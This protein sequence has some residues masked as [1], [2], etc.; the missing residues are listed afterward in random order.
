MEK[1]KRVLL[2]KN[3]AVGWLYFYI[4]FVTEVVCFYYI[5][6][7]TNGSFVAWLIPFLYDALAFVPQGIIGKL[8]DKYPKLN[9]GI[10][11]I[12]LL[13]V[14]PIMQ[15]G[16]GVNTILCL[17]ILTLGNCIMHISGAEDTLRT[18]NGMLSHPAIFVAG[19]SFG[20]ITR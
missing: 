15:F 9:I 19:G 14:A 4:H 16:L 17:I 3:I 11:G 10:L 1:A 12:I 20:V 5:S 7:V 2:S 18:S 6:K 8:N 13:A